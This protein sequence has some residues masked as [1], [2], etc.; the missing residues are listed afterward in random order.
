MNSDAVTK[1]A[2]IGGDTG[3]VTAAELELINTYTRK[4][5]KAEEVFVFSVVL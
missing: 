5:L 1:A 2:F 3:E 4:P